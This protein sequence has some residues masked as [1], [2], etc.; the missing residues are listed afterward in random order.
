[1][2]DWHL[3]EKLESDILRKKWDDERYLEWKR[4][5]AQKK[6]DQEQFQEMV[7]LE[8]MKIIQKMRDE[9]ILDSENMEELKFVHKIA[10]LK[11]ER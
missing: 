6:A 5:R 10:D 1:M 2:D 4:E 9:D 7:Q 8:S 3:F 11:W